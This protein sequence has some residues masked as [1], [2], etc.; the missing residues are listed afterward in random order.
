[1]PN[2]V[3]YVVVSRPKKDEPGVT[4]VTNT[5][6]ADGVAGDPVTIGTLTMVRGG[7]TSAVAIDQDTGEQVDVEGPFGTKSAAG[8][9]VLA[10]AYRAKRDAKAQ[11]KA[12]KVS[13][14]AAQKVARD[15]ERAAK[16]AAKAV[17]LAEKAAA[18]EQ[19]VLDA[20]ATVAV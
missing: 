9:A 20:A 15:A 5:V 10:V 4:E 16:K 11:A 14:L 13:E 6:T 1:M 2:K 7:E 17:E 8:H 18:A 12:Q 3:G 19:A